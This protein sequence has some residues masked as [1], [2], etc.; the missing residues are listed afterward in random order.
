[1]RD[2]L[3][4]L[5]LLPLCLAALRRPWVGVMGWTWISLMNPHAL[6]WH[7]NVMP[8]AAIMAGC[9]LLGMLLGKDRK[10]FSPTPQTTVLIL[11]MLWMCLTLPFA[12]NVEGSIPMWKRVMKIDF[13][14]LVS[15]VLL[16]S[17]RHLLIF[18]WVVVGSIGYY[19]V[20]GGLFTLLTGGAHRVW[21]PPNTFIEGNN[22]IALALVIIIPLL[23]F[24]QLQ[25]TSKLARLAIT[26][27]MGLCIAAALGTHS[28]GALLAIAAMGLALWWY[29]GK[30]LSVLIWITLAGLA[31]FL[32]LPEHWFER[33]SSIGD[34]ESDDSALGR[35]NAWWM[36]WNLAK[37]RF[38]GGG[39]DIYNLEQFYL[40]APNQNDVHAAHSIYFQVL[41]EQGFVGLGLFILLWW[42]VWREAGR[43]GVAGKKRPETRWVAELG[44]MCRVSIIGYAVGGAF[45]SLAYFDLPYNIL[46][47]VV[48]ARRWLKREGWREETGQ[49]DSSTPGGTPVKPGIQ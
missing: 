11:F 12:F 7:L 16:H 14:I 18:S 36:A 24:L 5:I 39:F 45:L 25:L 15:L 38:F 23:R 6:A 46:I 4:A 21:G 34:Y 32:F 13:M 20:K 17:K 48:V 31:A 35:I 42:L 28:R 47:M 8:V 43:L 9:T 26:L 22:E 3:L 33:M 41:G 1:M 49:T 40:Y 44:A 27:G 37:D 10:D 29:G 2:L 30:N 19:G